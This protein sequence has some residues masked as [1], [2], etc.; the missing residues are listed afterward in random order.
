MAIRVSPV[1]LCVGAAALLSRP[2]AAAERPHRYEIVAGPGAAEIAVQGE[3]RGGDAGALCVAEGYGRFV[4]DLSLA[5]GGAAQRAQLEGDCIRAPACHSRG[6][7]LRYRFRLAEAARERPSRG[8]CFEHNGALLAPPST[9]LLRPSRPRERRRIRF[10]VRAPAPTSFVSGTRHGPSEDA[11]ES[12]SADIDSA[13]YAGFGEFALATIPLAGGALDVAIAPGETRPGQADLVRWVGDAGRAV[14]G[15]FGRLPVA[16]VLVILL[17]G[18]QRPIGHGSTMGNGGASVIVSVGR[19]ATAGDLAKDWVLVHELVHTALPNVP[20][21]Q[22]WIEEG[23]ATYVEPLARARAGLTPPE[24]FWQELRRGL[25][26]GVSALRQGGLDERPSWG[27]T[28]WGGALFWL[29]ADIE[30][31]ERTG[32]RASL[33]DALRGIAG[34]GGSI[35]VSWPPER[36]LDTADRA[37]G[38]PVLRELR[39]RLGASAQEIDIDDLWRRLGVTASGAGVTLDEDAPLAS[40][41]RAIAA[42]APSVR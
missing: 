19:E 38:V 18:G 34:A 8:Q 24:A 28:Y 11:Y 9:W 30:I 13:P 7:T 42:P 5:R 23:L 4:Q 1:L 10:Q 20:R 40:L 2:A 12:D 35:E 16:R 33:E 27:G 39:A 41:R 32:Q 17:P 3:L 15:Y 22:R 29:L 21:R 6:C 36:V 14:A 26:N 31:R 37:V 25:P